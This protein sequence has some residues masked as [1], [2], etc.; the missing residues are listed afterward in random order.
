M[1][2]KGLD[3]YPFLAQFKYLL[4]EGIRPKTLT[5]LHTKK[6]SHHTPDY[7]DT[8]RRQLYRDLLYHHRGLVQQFDT[9]SLGM[10]CSRHWW[11]AESDGNPN[12]ETER[13]VIEEACRLLDVPRADAY[14]S[15]SMYIVSFDYLSKLFQHVDLDAFLDGFEPGY[16]PCDT[17]AHGFE[18]AVCYGLRKFGYRVGLI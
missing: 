9:A 4:D 5:K 7:A 12:F 14:V 6:S 1:E 13:R 18:R 2:N 10:A 8:W 15:G 17:L 3:V 16:K 11:I